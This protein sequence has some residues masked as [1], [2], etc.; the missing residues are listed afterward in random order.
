M[1]EDIAV[2]TL[3]PSLPTAKVRRGLLHGEVVSRLRDMIIEGE[4]APGTKLR[5]RIL[6]ERLGISRTPLRE[7][8]KVL[9]ADGLVELHPSR[10]ATVA[11][12]R[13]EE[14]DEMFAVMGALEALSGELAAERISDETIAE[15]RV[16]HAQMLLHYT[17]GDL[18][19]YFALNQQ[20]HEAILDAAANPTLASIY[21]SLAGRVR[22]ARYLANMSKTRWAEAVEEHEAIL[23]ALTAR[24]GARLAGLLKQHLK[25]KGETVRESL[26]AE[27][28]TGEAAA[29]D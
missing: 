14:I 20:I 3:E 28:P 18:G 21:R 12:L 25:N 17:R 2:D 26:L 10:G 27:S 4:L 29:R 6:C 23:A 19:A 11:K 15:I 13:I 22:R 8:F 9:A 7:A 24:D 5:E 16:L 1:A